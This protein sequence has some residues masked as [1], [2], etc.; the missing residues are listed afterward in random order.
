MLAYLLL[1]LAALAQ[2]PQLI[3]VRD[4]VPATFVPVGEIKSQYYQPPPKAEQVAVKKLA[5]EWVNRRAASK[6]RSSGFDYVGM[7]TG[8]PADGLEPDKFAV[9][10]M[11]FVG[12]PNI[13]KEIQTDM[14][15]YARGKDLVW[16]P[17][18]WAKYKPPPGQMMAVVR[19]KI[20]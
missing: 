15:F 11:K 8:S 17:E 7:F 16:P 3:E 9:Y 20:K 10:R 5:E 19:Q 14:L 4:R 1:P 2:E 18:Q 6:W 12:S 13:A